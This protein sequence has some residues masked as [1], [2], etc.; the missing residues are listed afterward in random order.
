MFLK[1]QAATEL[2]QFLANHPTAE[3]I[4]TFHPSSEV[5][6]R[7]YEL[8]HTERD[9][10]LTEEERKELESYLVM[11]HL[12]ELIKLEAHRQLRQRAS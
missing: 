2:A 4:V 5:A 6:E 1:T 3:Q 10:S 7:A 9:G 8:I 12:M 11:E